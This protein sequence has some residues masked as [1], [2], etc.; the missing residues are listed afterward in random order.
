MTT[1]EHVKAC[2]EKSMAATM[3]SGYCVN[4]DNSRTLFE[5]CEMISQTYDK[6]GGVTSV[7]GRYKDGSK[8]QF[9]KRWGYR[10]IA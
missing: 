6:D 3:M 5:P 4:Y 7:I 10:V 2:C 9:R 1:A 8:L